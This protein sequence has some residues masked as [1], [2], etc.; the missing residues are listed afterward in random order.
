MRAFCRWLSGVSI[1]LM[2][3]GAWGADLEHRKI[4]IWSEGVRLAGDIYQPDGLNAEDKL[5]G[6][7]LVTGWGGAKKNLNRAYA[8]QFAELGFVVLTFDFK[9]WGE[10]NG[11]LLL[12]EALPAVDDRAE[13]EVKAIHVRNVVDPFSMLADTRAALHYL[14]GEKNVD[15]TNMGI[16]GTSYGGGLSLVTAAN[17]SRI[18]ALVS[19]IG[20]L[21]NLANLS[22]IP[23]AAMRKRESQRAR[24]AIPAFPGPES[25]NPALKGY[26]DYVRMKRYDTAAYW[27]RILTPTLIIDAENEELF[28]RKKNGQALHAA[29]KARVNSSYL[30]L[31]G[32]HYD[33]YQGESYEKALK[34]AQDWFVKYLKKSEG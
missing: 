17:D 34:A 15:A 14:A 13:V 31:P 33:I 18:R 11:P 5:P 16:W 4:T 19:Q 24:G 3:S 25:K 1:T 10:S 22:M 2:V 32:K 29:I 6:L 21:D 27:D 26:P 12:Q 20:A 30:V 7:L 9:G 8:P 23:A 28:D